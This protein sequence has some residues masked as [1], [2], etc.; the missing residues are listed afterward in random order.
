[1]NAVWCVTCGKRFRSQIRWTQGVASI[2]YA[3]PGSY[4]LVKHCTDC[5]AELRPDTVMVSQ[6]RC[7]DT[8]SGAPSILGASG[9]RL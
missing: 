9:T 1:M 8:Y 2:E 4:N 3:L 5:G 7:Y 6:N